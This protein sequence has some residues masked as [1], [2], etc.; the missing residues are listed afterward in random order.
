VEMTKG[1]FQNEGEREI[2]IEKGVLKRQGSHK[3]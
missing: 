1:E 2:R 3:K